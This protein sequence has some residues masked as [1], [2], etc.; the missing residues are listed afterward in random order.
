MKKMSFEKGE[1]VR[2]KALDKAQRIKYYKQ[3][4]ETKQ[5]S[6]NTTVARFCD[7]RTLTTEEWK[8]ELELERMNASNVQCTVP[9][10]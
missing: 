6:E 1:K 9:V 10:N 8:A 7:T 5:L 4:T 2:A 3:A